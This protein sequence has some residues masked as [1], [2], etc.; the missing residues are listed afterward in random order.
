MNVWPKSG[1]QIR[2]ISRPFDVKHDLHVVG[3][4]EYKHRQVDIDDHKNK[5]RLPIITTQRLDELANAIEKDMQMKTAVSIRETL[6][7][8]L[9]EKD[10]THKTFRSVYTQT[11]PTAELTER[12]AEFKKTVQDN[13]TTSSAKSEQ[14]NVDGIV[15]PKARATEVG[16][17]SMQLA[18]NLCLCT[19][20]P[21][22]KSTIIE[23]T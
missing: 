12:V 1:Q 11:T 7:K 4:D 6:I 15:T 18:K 9:L 17:Y 14:D 13:D 2:N 23:K 5:D 8:E 20:K 10:V 22:A 16:R 19:I 21:R 3:P